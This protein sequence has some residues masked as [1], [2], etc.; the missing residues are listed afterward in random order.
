MDFLNDIYSAPQNTLMDLPKKQDLT[1]LD[2]PQCW[3]A[4]L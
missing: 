3:G 1:R 4:L 2:D